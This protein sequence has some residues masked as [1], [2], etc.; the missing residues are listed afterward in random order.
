MPP[1]SKPLQLWHIL[2]KDPGEFRDRVATFA[3][4]NIERLRSRAAMACT[5]RDQLIDQL[6]DRIGDIRPYLTER[7]LD[8]L[9]DSFAHTRERVRDS[10]IEGLHNPGLGQFCYA[11]A[12]AARPDI[13]IETGV[14]F[15][16]T[17]AFFLKALQING[18]GVLHSIDLPPLATE[19]DKVGIFVPPDLKSQWQLHRGKSRRLLPP[20]LA[21]LPPIDLFL[22]D[23]L[24]TYRNMRFEYEVVWPA[25]KP[26]GILLSDDV[27]LNRAFETFVR[28]FNPSF[29]AVDEQSLFGVAVK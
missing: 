9:A 11:I 1:I 6:S 27:A 20:L 22:H 23:S 10:S 12:R 17:S 4:G 8:Q 5:G 26:G 21:D 25:L 16:V 2:L 24:H 19:T 29:A 18:K 7:H 15:G 28:R 3:E 14:A 13:I